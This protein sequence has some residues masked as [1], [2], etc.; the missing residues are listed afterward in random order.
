MTTLQIERQGVRAVITPTGD[1][2]SSTAPKLR[3]QVQALLDR[4]VRA[5][6]FDLASVG[7]VD[8]QGLGLLIAANNSLMKIGGRIEVVNASEELLALF[9]AMRL[10]R[11]FTIAGL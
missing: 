11:H 2:T 3:P 6:T 8:S 4:G 10:D 1:L 5:V 7:V 9:R